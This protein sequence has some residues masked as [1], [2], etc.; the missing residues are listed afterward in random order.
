MNFKEIK[1]PLALKNLAESHIV[2]QLYDIVADV[3][4]LF[5]ENKT[6]YKDVEIP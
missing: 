1:D 2:K 3:H 4:W 6:P 5:D